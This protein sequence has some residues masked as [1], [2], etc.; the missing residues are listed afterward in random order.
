MRRAL[1]ISHVAFE[2]LG[3]L[4][5]ALRGAGF[6]IDV[7][8]ASVADWRSLDFIAPE[9]VVV[10]GGPIG[11][12]ESDAFPFLDAEID[13]I[14]RRLIGERPTLGVCLGAQL[15]AAALGAKVYPGANGREIGWGRLTEGDGLRQEDAFAKFLRADPV[16]LHWHGDTFD[17]P[18]GARRLAS[19]DKYANQAFAIGE[20][21]LGVQFHIEVTA[22]G[23]ERWYVGHA[24]ELARAGID[25]S[26]LRAESRLHAPVLEA[27]AR[28]FFDRWIDETFNERAALRSPR[29]VSRTLC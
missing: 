14:R 12:Y 6:E 15:M 8:E 5:G 26:A 13:A 3:S 22:Q 25:V 4:E 21:A 19:S 17:L 10:L 1:T 23:L 29:A 11:V 16:V 28:R 7:T 20:Y 9:L 27:A 2:N 24:C 18:Q